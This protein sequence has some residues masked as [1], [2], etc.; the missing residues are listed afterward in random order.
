MDV[1]FHYYMTYLIA[2]R[3]GFVPK[4][5]Q[6]LAFA[7]QA[8]DDNKIRCRITDGAHN[9][10]ENP[11]SQTMDITKPAEVLYHI[12]PVFH[13]VPWCGI[14]DRSVIS[15]SARI[16]NE[17]SDKEIT[18]PNNLLAQKMMQNALD[19]PETDE[20]RIYRIG[21]AAHAYV[22]T[23]AHQNFIGRKSPLNQIPTPKCID[24]K[25]PTSTKEYCVEN[26]LDTGHGAFGHS[27]DIPN[28]V[29]DDP[30]LIVSRVN[31]RERF[32]DAARHL[33]WLLLKDR[34]QHATKTFIQNN[35]DA[36][37]K[38]LNEDIGSECS[39]KTQRI[40][41][42]CRRAMSSEYGSEALPIYDE[43]NISWAQEAILETWSGL[44]KEV[45]ERLC[46]DIGGLFQKS[47]I[48]CQWAQP[49]EYKRS[50]WY[51]FLEAVKAHQEAGTAILKEHKI[52]PSSPSHSVGQA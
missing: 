29:W 9:F 50:D 52:V 39:T 31:N 34:D 5:A 6:T 43:E 19:L 2:A 18:S 42:Y 3:A 1:E 23:W 40:K 22:D 14:R 15:P 49:L 33:F 48:D 32:L 37:L 17:E 12:Y 45:Q 46:V 38:D 28:N 21:I 47:P 51:K 20:S 24:T 35:V 16:D 27:P 4:D 36:L 26:L 11:L 10:Y 41:N 30:R 7:S 8:V 44:I 25:D 13:F